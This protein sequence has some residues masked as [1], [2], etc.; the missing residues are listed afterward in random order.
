MSLFDTWQNLAAASDEAVDFHWHAIFTSFKAV[1]CDM[2]AQD[3]LACSRLGDTDERAYDRFMHLMGDYQTAIQYIESATDLPP[4]VDELL[5]GILDILQSRLRHFDESEPTDPETNPVTEEKAEIIARTF[6]C[7]QNYPVHVPAE[8]RVALRGAFLLHGACAL[9]D[10]TITHLPDGALEAFYAHYNE[11]LRFCLSQLDDLHARKTA[12]TY[13]DLV[14]R[15]WE[16]LQDMIRVQAA[17]LENINEENPEQT[18]VAA[19]VLNVLRQAYQQTGPLAEALQ[20]LSASTPLRTE[21]Y[22]TYETFVQRL[23]QAQTALQTDAPAPPDLQPFHAALAVE[24]DALF[25][26]QRIAFLKIATQWPN[27]VA[28]EINLVTEAIQIFRATHQSLVDN[29]IEAT[30]TEVQ[31]LQGIIETME[32]KIG[33]MMDSIG[34]FNGQT[35]NLMQSFAQEKNDVTDEIRQ[36]AYTA[37]RTA[38]FMSPPINKNDV[39]A[40]FAR[41]QAGTAFAPYRADYEK[42]VA[43]YNEKIE[44]AAIRFKREVLF[45]EAAT[46]EEILTHSVS[47]LRESTSEH[48]QDTA[49]NLEGA[50]NALEVLLCKNGITPIRPAPHDPFNGKEHEVLMAEQQ[51]GFAKGEIIKRVGSGYRLGDMILVRANV[52]AAR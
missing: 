19:N 30:D 44:K 18:T 9:Y 5:A 13:M 41:C 16:V 51:E 42:H 12:R 22:G 10:E 34:D 45:Y 14:Q 33:S 36:A 7:I 26:Q 31:I 37:I 15:E 23:A 1:A 35:A 3:A 25:G 38:W 29:P 40:F 43:F 11:G 17:A 21:G 47:R 48:V 2:L 39:P 8:A 27:R 49:A 28:D 20:R 52:I 46:Y 32:I 6:E 24:I 4:L 50:Y